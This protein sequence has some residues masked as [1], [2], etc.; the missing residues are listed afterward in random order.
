MLSYRTEYKQERE[1]SFS[2]R[3]DEFRYVRLRRRRFWLLRCLFADSRVV[4]SV[5][6]HGDGWEL[7]GE[8]EISVFSVRWRLAAM[9]TGFPERSFESEIYGICTERLY[10]WLIES[11]CFDSWVAI[12]ALWLNLWFVS[13]QY[14]LCL[15]SP[16][17]NTFVA[18]WGW[19]VR[20]AQ[21]PRAWKP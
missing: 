11:S 17:W 10:R 19:R 6:C 1:R 8:P 20:R 12:K 14:I 21:W 9:T 13:A 15:A 7:R 4:W 5:N 3:R 16:A 2:A 18:G